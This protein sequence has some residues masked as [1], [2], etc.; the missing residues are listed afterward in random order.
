MNPDTMKLPV[1]A[2]QMV[3]A[4]APTEN[5]HQTPTALGP[6]LEDPPRAAIAKVAPTVSAAALVAVTATVG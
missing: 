3:D 2:Q 1:V 6:Q 5:N 4:T